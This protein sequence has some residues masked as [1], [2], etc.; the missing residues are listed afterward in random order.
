MAD[1]R[2]RKL[3]P[4]THLP[5][6]QRTSCIIPLSGR[7]FVRA[8]ARRKSGIGLA[9]RGRGAPVLPS[10]RIRKA[11]LCDARERELCDLEVRSDGVMVR[12][13]TAGQSIGIM[14]VWR[15][16]ESHGFQDGFRVDGRRHQHPSARSLYD[17][18]AAHAT[19][20]SAATAELITFS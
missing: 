4:P 13:P 1:N 14:E 15:P 12:C 17:E 20:P 9:P 8:P 10:R 19:L 6:G 5:D 7:R 18:T 3:R 11:T 2:L 16:R